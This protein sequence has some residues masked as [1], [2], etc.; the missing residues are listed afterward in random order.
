MLFHKKKVE[1]VQKVFDYT[2]WEADLGFLTLCINRKTKISSDYVIKALSNQL[3]NSN[4][5]VRNEDISPEYVN[6]V[7]DVM[8]SLSDNYK[9][10]LIEKYFASEVELIKFVAETVYAALID[11]AVLS[12]NKKMQKQFSD[13]MSKIILNNNIKKGK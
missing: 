11:A 1:P 6:I 3:I 2:K 5:Y 7:N 13:E 12:N 10:F 9:N 4:D 8:I